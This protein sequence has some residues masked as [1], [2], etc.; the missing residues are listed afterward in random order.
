MQLVRVVKKFK[1][2]LSA[3]QKRKI[4]FLVILMI[5]GGFLEM[6]SVSLI[7]PFMIE[8]D[9]G[10]SLLGFM[11][12]GNMGYSFSFFQRHESSFV[13]LS[14]AIREQ[15]IPKERYNSHQRQEQD[16]IKELWI[17][18]VSGYIRNYSE[19]FSVTC[20]YIIPQGYHLKAQ[21]QAKQRYDHDRDQS[22]DK[23]HIIYPFFHKR[24]VASCHN[25]VCLMIL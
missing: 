16:Q 15:N 10:R 12:P 18:F 5:I 2:I 21:K 22:K 20:L 23:Q 11:G 14:G 19:R 24:I 3:D 4:V 17:V 1:T 25:S 9:P 7:L 8:L 13:L 6:A